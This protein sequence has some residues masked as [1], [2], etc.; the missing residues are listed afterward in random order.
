[1]DFVTDCFGKEEHREYNLDLSAMSAAESLIIHHPN[2][3]DYNV[4]F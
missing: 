3:L 1:M 2:A 4:Y